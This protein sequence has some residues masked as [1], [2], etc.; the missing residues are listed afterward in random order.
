MSHN[1]FIAHL[2]VKTIIAYIGSY[3]FGKAYDKYVINGKY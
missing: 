1:K 3:L 2:I